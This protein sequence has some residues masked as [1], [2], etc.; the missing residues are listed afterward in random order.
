MLERET[1]KTIVSYAPLVSIDIIIR[2]SYDRVLLG[3]RENKPAKGYWFVPGGRIFKN[4]SLSA[5]FTRISR[6]E[7]GQ[8]L[9][10]SNT[11]LLGPFDHIYPDSI[12]EDGIQ[13]HY[14]AIAYEIKQSKLLNLPTDQHSQYRW[15]TFNELRSA[16]NVHE[17]TKAYFEKFNSKI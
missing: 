9:S 7:L 5:A 16:H 10:F 12:F 3:K 13:T 17:N 14:V 2:D 1:F 6:A 11:K 4:E 8:E 15:F